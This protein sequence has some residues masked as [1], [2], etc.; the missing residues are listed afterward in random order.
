MQLEAVARPQDMGLQR[1]IRLIIGHD[2]AVRRAPV[3]LTSEMAI[4]LR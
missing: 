1:E 4:D 3:L 2:R